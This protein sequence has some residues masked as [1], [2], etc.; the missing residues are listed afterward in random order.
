MAS[1][2]TLLCLRKILLSPPPSLLLMTNTYMHYSLSFPFNSF[3]LMLQANQF[4]IEISRAKREDMRAWTD[5]KTF[6]K[7]KNS[8]VFG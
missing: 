4:K 3:L 2:Y 7:L 8:I 5:A 1:I 6:K